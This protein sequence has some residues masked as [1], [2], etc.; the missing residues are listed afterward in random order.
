MDVTLWCLLSSVALRKIR[1]WM[2]GI[3]FLRL[4]D[5][6]PKDNPEKRPCVAMQEMVF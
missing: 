5:E 1:Y 4:V 3:L 6:N 2:H